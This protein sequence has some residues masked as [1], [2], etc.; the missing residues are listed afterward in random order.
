MTAIRAFKP[1]SLE[2]LLHTGVPLGEEDRCGLATLYSLKLHSHNQTL[3]RSVLAVLTRA[4][5]ET[6]GLL[7]AESGQTLL[8]VLCA[9]SNVPSED[10]EML[11]AHGAHE[12]INHADAV[13][14]T[15]P[16]QYLS[17]ELN[18]TI[19]LAGLRALLEYGAEVNCKNRDGRTLHQVAQDSGLSDICDLLEEHGA[20]P[21][22]GG[23]AQ[24]LYPVDMHVIQQW[25]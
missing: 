1:S 25:I 19:S 21:L 20:V 22:I 14:N 15:P 18:R 11:L 12:D 17:R 5:L 24:V 13:G 3:R 8:H 4:G 6:C 7:Y 23:G 9:N 10:I 16:H 2:R